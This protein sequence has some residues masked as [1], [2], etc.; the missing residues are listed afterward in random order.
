MN[1]DEAVQKIIDVVAEAAVEGRLLLFVGTGF[2][3]AV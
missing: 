2:S 1:H 3:R